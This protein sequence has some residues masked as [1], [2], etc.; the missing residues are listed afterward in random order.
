MDIGYFLKL[1]MDKGASDMF[2]STGAPVHIKVEGKLYPLGNTGLPGGMAKK[3]AYSLMDE[4]QVPQFE[5]DLELNMAIAVKDVGRFR[6]NVFKQRGEVGLVIRSIKSEIPSIEQLLLP[7]IYKQIIMEPRGLVLVVGSTGSGKSTTLASMIDHR[8][9]NSSGHILTI[10]DPIEYL[11]RHKKSIVN[12]REV[13]MDTHGFHNALKNAMREAPD[14]ILI[15]EIRDTETMDAAIAFSETGHLCL[16]T[17]HS[18]NADQT[19]ERILNFFPDAAHK[20]VLMNL[21]LNLKSVISQRLVIG[22]DGRRRPAVEVLINTPHIR[23]LL[24]RGEVHQIKE[25]MERSLQEGMQTFDQALFKLYKEGIIELEE[26]L[27]KADSR[28]GLALKI[29][30]AE[31]AS[32]SDLTQNDP[33]DMTTF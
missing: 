6:V 8:N 32:G 7:Q 3:I 15:G 18:N 1:M 12:Q 11:H 19:I 14:V 27:S 25:A 24:R 21:A 29:R 28:D 23:D 2:L 17:L 9:T 16:A 5:R 26:A 31:G 4:G 20:N 10:E 13:G 22:K 33:Y 30:L